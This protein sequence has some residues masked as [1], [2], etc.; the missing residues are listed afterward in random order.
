MA[1]TRALDIIARWGVP[2][3]VR[4]FDATEF[5]AEEASTKLELPPN[6]VFKTLVVQGERTG[7]AL[8][9]IPGNSSLSLRKLAAAMSDKRADLIPLEDV[10]RITGYVKGGVSPL[11]TKRRMPIF[12]DFSAFQH[13]QISFSAGQRGL[14]ILMAPGHFVDASKATVVDLQDDA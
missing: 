4:S 2:F 10:P 9:V 7:Y 11:G 8:A 5:T 3:E 13:A 12:L 6:M 1:K 14:Q